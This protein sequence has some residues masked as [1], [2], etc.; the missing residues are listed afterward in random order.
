MERS[1]NSLNSSQPQTRTTPI[2]KSIASR[3]PVAFLGYA[4]LATT[5]LAAAL[6]PFCFSKS[7]AQDSA[8]PPP[9]A[10]PSAGCNI[11]SEGTTKPSRRSRKRFASRSSAARTRTT[12]CC[13]TTLKRP[14]GRATSIDSGRRCRRWRAV[15][16]TPREDSVNFTLG[17]AAAAGFAGRLRRVPARARP[18]ARS[19]PPREP[20]R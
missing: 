16:R 7:V 11:G 4:L 3:G 9:S 12:A 8:V 19:G 10:T 2:R 17:V 18:P 14:G 13:T 5:F 1:K 15:D 6:A 20:L